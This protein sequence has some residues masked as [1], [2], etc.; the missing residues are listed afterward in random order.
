MSLK[1]SASNQA[2]P[3]EKSTFFWLIAGLCRLHSIPFDGQIIAQQYPP[4]YDLAGL[5]AALI[6]LDM[7][8]L[9]I[10]KSPK[11]IT[12][13]TLPCI[14]FLRQPSMGNMPTKNDFAENDALTGDISTNKISTNK[15]SIN[16]EENTPP[17]VEAVLIVR[18]N[19]DGLIYFPVGSE[20]PSHLKSTDIDE[21]LEMTYLKIEKNVIETESDEITKGK[22]KFGFQTFIPELFKYKS[23]WR[24][25]IAA[26]LAIQ[27]MG[28]AT[29]LFTQVIIDKVIVHHTLNTLIVIAFGLFMFMIFSAAMT[30]L[31]QFLVLHTG[32]RVDAVMGSKVFSHLFELPLRYFNYR[33][34]GTV[35]ARV[36]GAETIREF[37]SGTA[38]TLFLDLPFIFIYLFVMYYYSWQ[39]TLIVA[40]V[41]TLISILSLLVAPELRNRLNEQFKF[42]ARNQAFL[43]EYVSGM[44]TVKSLQM[45]PQLKRT[46]GDYLSTYLASNFKARTLSNTYNVIAN[47][48]EQAQTISILCFGAWLVMNTDTFTI[49]M[50]VAF[51]MFASRLSQPVLRMVGLWQEFQQTNI[52][53]RRLADIM[54]TPAEPYALTPLTER[55]DKCELAFQN[56][57]FRYGEDLPLLYSN[58]NLKIEAGECLTVMGPSGCGKSTLTKLMQGFYLPTEGRI[59]LNNRDI[60]HMSTNELRSYFGIVPQETT[61]FA[62]SIYSNLIMASPQASFE[63]LVQA[64]KMAEIHQ[65]IERLPKGYQTEIGENGTGLSGGQK[66]RIAIARALLKRPKILV[67]DEPLSS[68]DEETADQFSLTVSKLRGKVSILFI[69][70][71]IPEILKSE[72]SI[73]LNDVAGSDFT[74]ENTIAAKQE[75]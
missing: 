53:M 67:F 66:Q 40:V 50:L 29:P 6:D 25:V 38:V 51:Q 9:E 65:V 11:N 18:L 59:L 55:K 41:L 24:D 61:L 21:H 73:V 47:T 43:M 4:P 34:T 14:A 71:R 2:S 72:R 35:I 69:T 46:W 12:S 48:L 36:Q 5:K 20:K 31:R 7:K 45:E 37:I 60:R 64:C 68:L 19:E 27:L 75:S 42:G 62:G 16:D 22:E 44:E 26:S 23:I 57:S 1:S 54:D 17:F 52:A 15:I 32:N 10:S 28:L 13:S 58:F 74:A 39:L 8:P 56:V 3:M 49:G 30:W 63:Q 70:H 33:P